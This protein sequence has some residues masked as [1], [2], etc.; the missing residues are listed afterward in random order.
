MQCC[1]ATCGTGSYDY[2]TSSLVFDFRDMTEGLMGAAR[3]LRHAEGLTT[4]QT[5]S[6]TSQVQG[7]KLP[8]SSHQNLRSFP[9]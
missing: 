4:P 7:N 5:H 6:A 9:H 2:T 3:F 1:V 8:G